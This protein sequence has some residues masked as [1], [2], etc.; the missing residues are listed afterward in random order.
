MLH[1]RSNALVACHADGLGWVFVP[2]VLGLPPEEL[3]ETALRKKKFFGEFLN[4]GAAV[5]APQGIPV[6]FAAKTKA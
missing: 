1:S 4:S 6:T 5:T 3:L 2:Q